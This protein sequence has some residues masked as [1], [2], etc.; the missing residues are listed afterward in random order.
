MAVELFA[1]GGGT[2]CWSGCDVA[3]P[4]VAG[5]EEIAPSIAEKK[6]AP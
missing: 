4:P 6:F 5:D 2:G 3:S 1:V